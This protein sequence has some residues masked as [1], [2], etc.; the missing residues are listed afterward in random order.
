MPFSVPQQLRQRAPGTADLRALASRS[1]EVVL[2]AAVVGAA[3][4]LG[5]AGFEALTEGLLFEHVL[6]GPPW[7]QVVAPTLGLVLAALALR[8]LRGGPVAS[9]TDEYVKS[10]PEPGAPFSLKEVPARLVACIATLGSGG[11]LGYEGPSLYLGTATGAALHRHLPRLLRTVDR[12]SMLVAG[13]AAG[14]AAIFQAP[15]TGAVFALE[16]PYEDDLARHSLLP[17]LV[18]AAA[19]YTAFI[20]VHGTGALIPVAG[21]P[22]IDL[23][24]IGGALGVGVSCGMGARLYAFLLRRAKRIAARTRAVPRVLVAGA[25]IGLTVVVT[26]LFFDGDPLSLGAGYDG[27][28]WVV[29]GDP[30]LRA[31]AL[32][33]TVRAVATTATVAGGGAGGL[34][35]PLVV[36]GALT[37]HLIGGAIGAENESLFV[38]LGIAAFLGAGYR[39]PLAAVVFVAEATGRPGFVV[40]GLLAAVMAHIVAGR[41]SVS[42]YQRRT[43]VVDLDAPAAAA[44]AGAGADAGRRGSADGEGGVVGRDA[45]GNGVQFDDAADGGERRVRHVGE[46]DVGVAPRASR[47]GAARPDHESP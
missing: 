2:V 30:S 35:V 33:A 36:Q 39:V 18:G 31:V 22:A 47:G 37:G 4:G 26:R 45:A 19:G 11:P 32:L 24:D 44:A 9:T 16:V 29:D 14:V 43:V 8:V 21:T 3:A 41:T 12:R 1:R 6:A 40:P 20:L 42:G 7:L 46:S 27:I 23:R 34:F 28:A 10:E 25:A 5:V 15:A 13:A 17:A 38:V